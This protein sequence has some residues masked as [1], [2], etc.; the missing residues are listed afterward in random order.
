MPH[1]GNPQGV[2]LRLSVCGIRYGRLKCYP[3]VSPKSC[4]ARVYP[5]PKIGNPQ[6]VALRY[7][8]RMKTEFLVRKKIR[9]DSSLYSDPSHI[10]SVTICTQGSI[11]V[12]SN[13]E[14][15]KACIQILVEYSNRKGIPIFAYCFMPDHVHLL[16]SAATGC[17][18]PSF[19]GGF[20]SLCARVGWRRF[21]LK[22]SFWQ[23]RY[24]DHFLRK[25]EDI[26]AVIRYILDNSVRRGLV[27]DWRDYPLCGS[28]VYEL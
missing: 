24:Y 10:C 5:L 3:A 16:L 28:L 26:A 7:V 27:E 4:R 18:V 1:S 11:Q 15:G 13:G 9:L 17:S 12:F 19:I 8:G 20:K 21:D 25:E 23:K 6:G 2:A 22:K 14:F